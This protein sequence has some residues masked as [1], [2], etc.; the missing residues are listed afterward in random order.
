MRLG[1]QRGLEGLVNLDLGHV[2]APQ[3]RDVDN[4]GGE[5]TLAARVVFSNNEDQEAIAIVEHFKRLKD[6]LKCVRNVL[7]L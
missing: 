6:F 1:S 4:E 5:E 3:V 7:R 2:F